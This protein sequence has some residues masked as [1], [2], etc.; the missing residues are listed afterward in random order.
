MR[1]SMFLILMSLV[2]L[3][4]CQLLRDMEEP[5]QPDLDE[6]TYTMPG[7]DELHEGTWL[8]WPHNHTYPGHSQ[9]HDGTFIAITKA[10]HTGER[11]HIIVYDQDEE[12]RVRALLAHAQLD[13]TQVDFYQWKTDDY[14]V[15]D[16][17]PIFTFDDKENLV[18]QNW[19]FNG[20]GEKAPFQ[21]CDQIP[22]KV[23]DRLSLPMVPVSMINEGG[24]VEIDGHGT[25]MAKKSSIL[26]SNRNPGMTQAEAEA[27]FRQY[28]G[29]TNFIWLEGKAGQEITDDHIDGTARFANARTIVTYEEEE[30]DPKEYR[31]LVEAKNVAGHAYDIVELPLTRY[32]FPSSREYGIYI[33]FYIGNEVVLVPNFEDPNDEIA[34]ARIQAIYPNRRVVGIPAIELGL[35]GGGVHCV[36]QQQPKT[37]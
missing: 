12:Q 22:T 8:Q 29:V 17:G 16:N 11:V 36:T 6:D 28:L 10:L 18:V 20:W 34:N 27:Y 2:T 5:P 7:E 35:D 4:N 21:Y 1:T 23:S 37:R 3:T 26:N 32:R 24:S 19:G 33:N 9:R 30:S 15:R 13:Q 31:Q 25:L 14:W